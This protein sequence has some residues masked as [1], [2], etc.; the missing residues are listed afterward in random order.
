MNNLECFIDFDD[1]WLQEDCHWKYDRIFT[2]TYKI[3]DDFSFGTNI[4]EFYYSLGATEY[5]AQETTND[6]YIEG[7][8]FHKA[9]TRTWT[10][11][12]RLSSI[13]TE[14]L[15]AARTAEGWLKVAAR[16]S[17]KD[18]SG[19]VHQES[20]TYDYYLELPPKHPVENLKTNAV[21]NNP[22]ELKCSWKAAVTIDNNAADSVDGYTVE[23]KRCLVSNDPTKDENYFYV[24]NLT[25]DETELS[26]NKY[27]LKLTEDTRDLSVPEIDGDFDTYVNTIINT[28]VYINGRDNTE[29]YF[30][31]KELGF[32]KGDYYKFIIYPHSHYSSEH[33]LIAPD[34]TESEARE[35]PN[36]VVR[37]FNGTDWVEGIVYV[38]TDDGTG[39]GVWKIA[40]S[41]YVRTADGWKETA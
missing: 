25:W 26:N 14:N 22:G 8:L 38:M 12:L 2:I 36:G 34:S 21:A 5:R 40:D 32:E 39:K 10:F 11:E 29:F 27:K 3:A 33:T 30:E 18:T 19:V 1:E 37:V 9:G 13:S 31:P 20:T 4:P 41:I 35:V 17:V 24:G 6:T 15:L 7:K 23:L 28:E 16:L